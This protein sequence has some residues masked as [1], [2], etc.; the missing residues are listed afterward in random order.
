MKILNAWTVLMSWTVLML[1]KFIRRVVNVKMFTTTAIV[2]QK[3]KLNLCSTL[4]WFTRLAFRFAF[5]TTMSI[6]SAV[7]TLGNLCTS[8][9]GEVVCYEDIAHAKPREEGCLGEVT[10][11]H[12]D[13]ETVITK[14][15]YVVVIKGE[16]R[17][18]NIGLV[19]QRHGYRT[20]NAHICVC[21]FGSDLPKSLTPGWVAVYGKRRHA[22]LPE[23][24]VPPQLSSQMTLGQL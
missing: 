8:Y 15:D 1:W 2:L 11:V 20:Q 23:E 19:Q 17:E 12:L 4:F 3:L 6:S 5:P 16:R 9:T 14:G 10:L 18:G 13:P 7:I 21:L 22:E 24:D